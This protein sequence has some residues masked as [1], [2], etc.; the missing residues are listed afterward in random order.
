MGHEPTDGELA[1]RLGVGKADVAA[2]GA[3]NFRPMSLDVPATSEE[4]SETLGE[5]L[6]EV[7]TRIE[8]VAEFEAVRSV[9]SDVP[10]RQR[11]MLLLYYFGNLTQREIAEY[12]DLSQMHVS[13]LLRDACTHLRGSVLENG[14][15]PPTHEAA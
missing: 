5:R 6:G 12:F 11:Q 9:A 15:S 10:V 13:R 1:A 7:D 14:D 4:E 8:K 2:A 3:A